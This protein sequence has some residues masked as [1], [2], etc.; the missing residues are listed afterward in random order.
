[1][2]GVVDERGRR[3]F[4]YGETSFGN[5]I[6]PDENSVFEIGSITKVFTA[7]LPAD[8]VRRGEVELDDPIELYL[9]PGGLRSTPNLI[10]SSSTRSLTLRS[11]S[12]STTPE[13]SPP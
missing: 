2:V 5:G 4:G 12:R 11:P 10:P 9:P 13:R 3:Y 1:V 6:L 7:T 8:M